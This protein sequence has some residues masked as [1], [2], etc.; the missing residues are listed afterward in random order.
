MASEPSRSEQSKGVGSLVSSLAK[1]LSITL[2]I[3]GLLDAVWYLVSPR[4]VGC[5]DLTGE[6]LVIALPLSLLAIGLGHVSHFKGGYRVGWAGAILAL[7]SLVVPP[8]NPG[9]GILAPQAS[10]VGSLRTLNTAEITY[11]T[12]YPHGFSPSLNSLRWDSHEKNPTERAAGL[13]D[14]VLASG[15]KSG[16]RFVYSAG[17]RDEKGRINAYTIRANPIQ[18]GIAYYYTDQTGVIRQNSSYPASPTDPPIG[19]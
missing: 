6:T 4:H 19:E 3:L 8:I 12:T 16:Y 7:I 17:P 9:R 5:I 14:D 13:I 2:G 1:G 10:A 18:A 15:E 11:A